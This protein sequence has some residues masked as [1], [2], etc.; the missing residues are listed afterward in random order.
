MEE[1]KGEITIITPQKWSENTEY[2][3]VLAVNVHEK[4]HD[5]WCVAKLL[6]DADLISFHAYYVSII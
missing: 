1:E 6:Q 5:H 3:E 4:R 2:Q